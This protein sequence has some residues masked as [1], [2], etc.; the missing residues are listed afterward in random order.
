M[1]LGHPRDIQ[2][3]RKTSQTIGEKGRLL[4]WEVNRTWSPPL[5]GPWSRALSST[6]MSCCYLWEHPPPLFLCISGHRFYIL[7]RWSQ[8]WPDP[9][10]TCC[11]GL[12]ARA[13]LG[14]FSICNGT[15][16]L[17]STESSK[18]R[19]GFRGWGAKPMTDSQVDEHMPIVLLIPAWV[20]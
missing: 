11:Q 13:Y 2:E 1:L 17:P 7:G 4:S 5:L 9:V 10:C 15:W 14:S 6:H 20:Q 3:F 18:G 16:A 8:N 19:R 12:W